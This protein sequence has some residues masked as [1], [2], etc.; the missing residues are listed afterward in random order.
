MRNILADLS[1]SFALTLSLF[2]AVTA[3]PAL[4]GTLS[5]TVTTAA[6]CTGGTNIIVLRMSSST[7]AHSELPS[8]STANYANNVICCSGVTGLSTSCGTVLLNLAAVTNSHVTENTDNTFTNHA[9]LSMTSGSIT[10]G[11]QANNC[12]G[13]DTTVASI[14]AASNSHIGTSTAYTTKVCATDV[15]VSLTFSVSNQGF[16][17]TATNI[18]PGPAIMA[19]STLSVTTNN[20]SGWNVTL[21]GDNK[22]STHNNLQTSGDTA[23][24]TDQTE[25]IN[26]AATSTAGNAVR[27]NSLTNSGNVLAFRVMTASSTNGGAFTASSWWGTTDNYAVDAATTLYA[28]ISSSTVSRQIGNAGAGSLSAS[29]HLNDVQYYLQ[30]PITQK[31]GTYSGN[32]T[33]TATANP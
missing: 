19:T 23:E 5:C 3:L 30:V 21:S 32:I 13:F 17:N 29:A 25:W 14:A 28:G 8:Q 24:I 10:V 22:S 31:N 1:T 20:T 15:P 4:A 12:T 16:A 27:I 26:G 2:I 9:C 11:Y 6:L 33:Y 7:N 18:T